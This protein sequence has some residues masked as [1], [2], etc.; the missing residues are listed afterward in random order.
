MW[1]PFVVIVSPVGDDSFC[2]EQILEP[3]DTK[4][5]LAQLAAETLY[6]SILRGL[7]RLDVH[8]T[9]LAIQCPGEKMPTGQ[10][11]TVAPR[12]WR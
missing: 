5:F 2:F 12:E 9:D 7:A 3:A 1:P 8:Q 4:S 11:R 6:K 10:L